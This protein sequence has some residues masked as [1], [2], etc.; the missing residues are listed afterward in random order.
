[1]PRAIAAK[2]RLKTRPDANARTK[3]Q[4]LTLVLEIAGPRAARRPGARRKVQRHC[5]TAETRNSLEH[6]ETRYALLNIVY[7]IAGGVGTL[8]SS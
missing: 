1:M 7:A 4:R 5:S 3:S 6:Q 8:C 2:W